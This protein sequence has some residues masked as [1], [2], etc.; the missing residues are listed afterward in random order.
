MILPYPLIC[1][2]LE[3]TDS[4]PVKGSIIQLAAIDVSNDFE[5]IEGKKF[6]SYV[7]PLDS[8]RNPE[9][10][11]VNNISED[12]IISEGMTLEQTLEMF[13]EFTQVKYRQ[14]YLSSWNTNFDI[15]FLKEQYRKIKREY[16]FQKFTIDLKAIAI[17]EAAKHDLEFLQDNIKM[18]TFNQMLNLE[19][20]GTKHDAL[21]DIINSYKIVKKLQSYGI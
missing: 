13:E 5:W 7:F 2:D 9:A 19:F 10:M 21:S 15:N 6:N 12:T 11:S 4:N 14:V 3:T 8:W 20:E 1:I 16:P 17:W 18:E